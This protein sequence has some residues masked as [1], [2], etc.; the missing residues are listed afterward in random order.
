MLVT[1]ETQNEMLIK[2]KKHCFFV[3]LN[4]SGAELCKVNTPYGIAGIQYIQ[5]ELG[6]SPKATFISSPDMTITR[7]VSRWKSGFGYGGKL[8]WGDGNDEL[9]ILN[10]KPNACG[11]MVGG[12]EKMPE[13]DKLIERLHD[14]ENTE[15]LIDGVPVEWDFYKSNHFID[16]FEAKPV[17]SHHEDLPR[18][19]FILHGS[20]GEFRGDRGSDFGVYYDKSKKLRSMAREID[21][22]FGNYLILTGKDA[23]DYYE[24]YLYVE[25]FAKEKRRLG[26]KLLFDEFMEISNETH[27]G[28]ISMNEITLG[29][30]YI[31]DE[32]TLFPVALRPDLPAYLVRGIPN[33]TPEMID[34]LGFENRAKKFGVYDYLLNSNIVPHGGGYVLP[35]ILSVNKVIDINGSRYFE[36][37]MQNDRGKQIISEVHELPYEYRGRTV[38]LRSV[39]IDSLEIVFK[40]IPKFVL[41]I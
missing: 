25:N 40:L 15:H 3:G 5:K 22:P 21:T 8:I 29:C 33:Y 41:K 27:Q 38:I 2:A 11:M 39:E 1:K 14:M 19:M 4:D 9:I 34:V 32:T 7:N 16:I 26:A 6:L 10:S 37:E 35:D 12:L 30:H 18:Y 36:V 31:R 13:I 24:R 28:L 17:S 23:R 20:S